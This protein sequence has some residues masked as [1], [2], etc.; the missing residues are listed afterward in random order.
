MQDASGC[1]LINGTILIT[2]ILQHTGGDSTLSNA[3]AT[4]K[5]P[6]RTIEN[7]KKNK[8]GFCQIQGSSW[9]NIMLRGGGGGCGGGFLGIPLL[10][11]DSQKKKKN[12][13]TI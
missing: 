2:A 12:L 13:L 4:S 10:S 7:I 11:P 3:I 6:A 1:S 5:G 9:I 8:K